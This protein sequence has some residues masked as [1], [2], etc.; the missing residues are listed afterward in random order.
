M[1]L[2]LQVCRRAS[3]ALDLNNLLFTSLSGHVRRANTDDFLAT[4][5][6]TLSRVLE[7]GGADPPFTL[8]M[9]HQEYRNKH[10]HGLL[11]GMLSVSTIITEGCGLP[12]A[13][14]EQQE[15]SEKKFTR[16]M[17]VNNQQLRPRL[18]AIFDE[19]LDTGVISWATGSSVAFLC[20]RFRY[21]CSSVAAVCLS[22]RNDFTAW[23]W[24]RTTHLLCDKIRQVLSLAWTPVTW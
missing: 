24:A 19:M 3:P 1:L 9:L 17:L 21:D 7:S 2:D 22:F 20:L 8:P 16:E 5:Y 11:F 14:D 10:E 23:P 18:L 6:D 15:S 4:Y 13:G 12:V